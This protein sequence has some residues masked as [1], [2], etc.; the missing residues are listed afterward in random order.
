MNDVRK[1]YIPRIFE[2]TDFRKTLG[3]ES[4]ARFIGFV[5]YRIFFRY[6]WRR[7]K[8]D[9]NVFSSYFHRGDRKIGHFI[10]VDLN[11]HRSQ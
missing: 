6:V 5:N 11:C 2:L 3:F 7:K 1:L 9:P 4:I 8:M 10:F